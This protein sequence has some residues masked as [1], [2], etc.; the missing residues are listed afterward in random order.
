MTTWF[1]TRHPGA[2]EW[3]RRKGL[4]VDRQIN[5]LDPACVE[6]GDTVIGV[7]PVNLAAG[8]CRKGARYI[9]LSVDLPAEVRGR[10]LTADEL[11]AFG[12]RLE[13]YVVQR[14]ALA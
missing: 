8:V 4:A 13:A 5:H 2:I 11:D 6:V 9:H 10:E 14:A 1:V 3:A 7:L 12:A